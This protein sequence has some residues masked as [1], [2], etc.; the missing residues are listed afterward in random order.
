MY[1]F[2]SRG[3]TYSCFVS[4]VGL[5][6]SSTVKMGEA[7]HACFYLAIIEGRVWL[8]SQLQTIS[9]ETVLKECTWLR[10]HVF[11]SSVLICNAIVQ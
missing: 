5:A 9:I 11:L 7:Q 3:I 8:I 1:F 6:F 4:V 10:C 2:G